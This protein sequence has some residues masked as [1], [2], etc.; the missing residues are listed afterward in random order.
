MKIGGK[1]PKSKS[2]FEHIVFRRTPIEDSIVF[3]IQSV[4]NFEEFHAL[5]PPPQPGKMRTPQGVV[6][7]LEAPGYVEARN[8]QD[9]LRGQYVLIKS[10]EPS[11]IEWDKVKLED[12]SSWQH[13]HAELSAILDDKEHAALI[14][15]IHRANSLTEE[16]LEAAAN[17]FFASQLSAA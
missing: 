4:K 7:D 16:M 6:D 11:E 13:A 14:Q 9:L 8:R 5:A 10:L 3:K 1:E 17:D 12:P 2:E 15:R